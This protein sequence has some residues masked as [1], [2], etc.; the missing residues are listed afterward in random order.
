ME[1]IPVTPETVEP[2]PAPVKVVKKVVKKVDDATKAA[3]AKKA[4]EELA[5]KK[6]AEELAAKK[7]AEELA[8]KKAAEEL[9]AEDVSEEEIDTEAEE[10]EEINV[11]VFTHK[12][13]RYLIDDKTNTVYDAKTQAII[14]TYNKTKDIIVKAKNIFDN[15]DEN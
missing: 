11:R 12:M 13:K 10:E 9:A 4:A 14:G 2:A 6:A 5:A 8:A 7:A 1:A 3:A 15:E